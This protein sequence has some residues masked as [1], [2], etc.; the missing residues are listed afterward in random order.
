[1]LNEQARMC[2]DR[3]IK[4]IQSQLPFLCWQEP[5]N[6]GHGWA[7]DSWSQ[8]QWNNFETAI[9]VVADIL[10]EQLNKAD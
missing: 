9:F 8:Q 7:Q 3:S 1:M 4:Y 5:N 2:V 10:I 6:N